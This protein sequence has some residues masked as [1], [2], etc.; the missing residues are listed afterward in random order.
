MRLKR[1]FVISI[2]LLGACKSP[3][4]SEQMDSIKSWLATAEMVGT[5]WLRHTTPDKYSRQTLELSRETVL[6][7]SNDLMASLPPAT[8]SAVLDSV[9]VR[10]RRHLD[11]MARL[12][13]A[14]NAPDF[15]LQL[16]SLR[17]D[18]KIVR[19]IADGMPKQ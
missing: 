19:Q 6:Q 17:A 2:A 11:Q 1:P 16:D 15:R 7:I 10:N 13:A 12:I 18:E 14:K 5:A 8:D 4:A 9:L 3:T